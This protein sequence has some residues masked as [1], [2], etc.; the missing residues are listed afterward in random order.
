MP[1]E[2]TRFR[3]GWE[4]KS[5]DVW[6]IGIIAFILL[7][8]KAPFQAKSIKET[9]RLIGTKPIPW[10]QRRHKGGFTGDIVI[11]S[12]CKAFVGKLLAKVPRKRATAEEALQHPWLLENEEHHY[13]AQMS[14]LE[15]DERKEK[16]H[17]LHNMAD[18]HN[19]SMCWNSTVYI[20]LLLICIGNINVQ[21][22]NLKKSKQSK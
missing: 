12:Q 5:H 19:A 4:L 16:S 8:G 3:H 20:F 17:L 1:P 14:Q 18:F 2:I 21:P 6:S 9:L 22:Y 7:V 11:S 10:P 15:A 13:K